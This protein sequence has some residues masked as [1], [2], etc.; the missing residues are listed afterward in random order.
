MAKFVVGRPLT[1][2]EPAIVVDPG[3]PA[4]AHRF[5]LVV[6]GASGRKSTPDQVLVQ[7]QSTTVVPNLRPTSLQPAAPAIP[8]P[9]RR[10]GNPS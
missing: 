1:T 3:L 8:C 5:E 6:I 7:V 4:G 10:K 2:R 9:P